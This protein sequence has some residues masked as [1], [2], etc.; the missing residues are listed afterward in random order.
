MSEISKLY[1]G[2]HV[3]YP[4]L[5]KFSK[6]RQISNFIK[7]R[8]VGAKLFHADRQTDQPS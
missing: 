2:F 4:F 8:P 1:I 6:N 3:K 7:T 5:D